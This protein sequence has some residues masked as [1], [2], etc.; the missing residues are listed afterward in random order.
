MSFF[1]DDYLVITDLTIKFCEPQNAPAD[2]QLVERKWYC[3][4]KDLFLHKGPQSAWLHLE[5]TTETHLSADDFVITDIHIGTS[6]PGNGFRGPWEGRPGGIWLQKRKFATHSHDALTAVDVLFGS[7]A[8]DPRPQWS[9]MHVPLE[10]KA[11][12]EVPVARLTLR[13]GRAQPQPDFPPKALRV[14]NDGT[15][16]VVQI[17]DTHMV[18]G[19]GVCKDA[20][21]T[22]GKPLPESE[23]DPLTVQFM[24]EILDAEQPDMV[25]LSGD[26]VHHN[27]PDTQSALFKVVAPIIERSIPFAAIFGNHDDEGRYALARK[28]LFS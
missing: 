16:K 21:D 15:F 9:L 18:T 6:Q 26:Q 7:D 11:P 17:S 25:I 1:G 27:V 3:V 20:I 2:H 22:D 19:I 23:A 10:L 4:H 12:S 28:S 5:Y 8:V 14:R 13:Y 24:R